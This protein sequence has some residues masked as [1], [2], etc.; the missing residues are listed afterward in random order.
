MLR[1]LGKATSINVRKVL[2]TCEEIGIAYERADDGPELARNP[3][4]LVPVI[5]DGDFVLWESGQSLVHDADGSPE[6]PG[7]VGL[8]R[9]AVAASGIP[10]A[11]SQ[12]RRLV[13]RSHGWE[14]ATPVALFLPITHSMSA[15][16]VARSQP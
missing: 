10:E 1:I 3:N 11:R 9:E 5:V 7:R 4:G 15:T 6:L 14:R 12:W 2:W 13:S 16:G 8:L